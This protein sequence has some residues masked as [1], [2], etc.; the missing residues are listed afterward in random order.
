MK[1]KWEKQATNPFILSKA[2]D[3]SSGRVV[4]GRVG[5]SQ[6]L[7]TAPVGALRRRIPVELGCS[8]QGERCVIDSKTYDVD[9]C[10]GVQRRRN[11]VTLRLPWHYQNRVTGLLRCAITRQVSISTANFSNFPVP[12]CP[13]VSPP[14]PHCRLGRRPL[15]SPYQVPTMILPACVS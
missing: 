14:A 5:A 4:E 6:A 13:D 12:R 11:L 9:S 3:A 1:G 15:V 7:C 8:A 10:R 2:S